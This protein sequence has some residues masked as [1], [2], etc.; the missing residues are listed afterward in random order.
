LRSH[1]FG[2]LAH[3]D[4]AVMIVGFGPH[5][6][7]VETA[8]VVSDAEGDRTSFEAKVQADPPGIGVAYRIGDGFLSNP[9]HRPPERRRVFGPFALDMLLEGQ[10]PACGL[11]AKLGQRRPHGH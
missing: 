11:A 8:S 6:I 1:I 10:R 3:T 5:P 4:Q 7:D 2:A 9:D